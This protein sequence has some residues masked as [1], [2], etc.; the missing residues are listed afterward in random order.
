MRKMNSSIKQIFSNGISKNK[1]RFILIRFFSYLLGVV[2]IFSGFTKLMSFN[3]FVDKLVQYVDLYFYIPAIIEYREVLSYCI[4]ILEIVLG[5][6]L[7]IYIRNS[8]VSIIAILF[9]LVF[10]YFTAINCFFSI[11]GQRIES[12]GCFGDVV[13]L[14]PFWS[15]I[16]STALLIIS[17]IKWVLIKKK[18]TLVS[19]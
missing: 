8:I 15:F 17:S 3:Y 1:Y 18:N 11:S 6:F 12:C 19:R 5:I 2:F 16:K 4:C 13:T 14:S 10:T 7:I 9:L